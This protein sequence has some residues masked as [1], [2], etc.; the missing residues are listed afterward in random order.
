MFGAFNEVEDLVESEMFESIY[1][2]NKKL[3][4]KFLDFTAKFSKK[5]Q[6]ANLNITTSRFTFEF[7]KNIISNSDQAI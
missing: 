4:N 7:L 3:K 1:L 6:T 5:P 2:M